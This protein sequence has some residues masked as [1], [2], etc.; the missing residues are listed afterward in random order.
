MIKKI[1]AV[2]A[3][4]AFAV[5]A[6]AEQIYFLTD[7]PAQHP[8]FI[9]QS[10]QTGTVNWNPADLG[11]PPTDCYAPAAATTSQCLFVVDVPETVPP[12]ATRVMLRLK[13]VAQLPVPNVAGAAN[14]NVFVL[15][16]AFNPN[17]GEN[18]NHII[19][20]EAWGTYSDGDQLR[21]RVCY[22]EVWLPIYDGKVYLRVG[23]RVLNG[24]WTGIT[25][26]L[27]GYFM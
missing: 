17:T 22:S 20:C 15:A 3:V 16:H 11:S 12:E 4:L 24:G 14:K 26:T 18:G 2:L 6:S 8:P 7:L 25:L 9:N 27:E 13:A 10:W 1:F 19:H 5:P 23:K 21:R